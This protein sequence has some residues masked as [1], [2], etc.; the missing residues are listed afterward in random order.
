[1]PLSTHSEIRCERGYYKLVGKL[2]KGGMGVVWEATFP[3]NKRKVVVKEPLLD[4]QHDQIKVE[5]LLIEAAILKTIN[6]ELAHPTKDENQQIIAAH[7]VRYV[8]QLTDPNRPILVLEFVDGQSMSSMYRGKPMS[9]GLAFQHSLALVRVIKAL[10]SKGV[11][12]RDISPDNLILNSTRGIVLIDF[13]TSVMQTSVRRSQHRERIVFKRGYSAPELMGGIPDVKSDVFSAGATMFYFLTGRNP[14]DFASG[15][16]QELQFASKDVKPDVSTH[17]WDIVRIATARDPDKRF[18]SASAMLKALETWQERNA[19]MDRPVPRILLGGNLI[20]LKGDCVEIGRAHVCDDAC[21]SFGYQ[22]PLQIS[23]R[24]N[25]RFVE[26]HHVRISIDASK[27]CWIEDLQTTNRT[28]TKPT[29]QRTFRVLTPPTKYRLLDGD[30]I[31]LAYSPTRG[32]YI[33]FVFKR[34]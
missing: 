26:K 18:Q 6:D 30:T 34:A 31:A 23:V 24:D 4:G 5:R 20:D 11:I 29:T 7:V 3:K 25:N 21:K 33:T 17:L 2:S 28:A 1:M 15:S 16:Q 9:E 14:A 10:H 19:R 32:P 12:H 27:D 13:G 22:R 8:D